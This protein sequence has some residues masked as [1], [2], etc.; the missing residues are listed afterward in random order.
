MSEL[1][2]TYDKSL[3]DEKSTSE[4]KKVFKRLK[5]IFRRILRDNI[6]YQ[7]WNVFDEI[8]VFKQSKKT[9]EI[10][11]HTWFDLVFILSQ[12]EVWSKKPSSHDLSNFNRQLSERWWILGNFIRSWNADSPSNIKRITQWIFWSI[13]IIIV[14]DGFEE[15][16]DVI[17][18]HKWIVLWFNNTK[19]SVEWMKRE[20]WANN[21]DKIEHAIIDLTPDMVSILE[22]AKIPKWETK[23]EL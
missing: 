11:A 12:R 14:N 15:A 18:K 21:W 9:Y 13:E 2:R 6:K 20:I 1:L 19:R 23:I 22:R 16:I 17:I 7:D 4:L 3:L 10:I 5:S 8:V